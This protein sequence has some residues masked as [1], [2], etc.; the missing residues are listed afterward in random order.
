M[1]KGSGELSREILA[2]RIASDVLNCDATIRGVIVV[3]ENA[4]LLSVESSEQSQG[5][6]KMTPSSLENFAALVK[7]FLEAARTASFELGGMQFIIGAFKGANVLLMDLPEYKLSL[8]IYLVRSANAET[9]Y[10][11]VKDTLAS[12]P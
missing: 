4:R 3:D 8:G 2:R 12:E 6:S 11:K 10:Y 9:I 7:L 1:E 5:I